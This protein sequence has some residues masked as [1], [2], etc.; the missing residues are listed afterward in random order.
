MILVRL[1]I[2]SWMALLA[3]FHEACPQEPFLPGKPHPEYSNRQLMNSGSD[4][5]K[6]SNLLPFCP[7]P[8][9]QGILPASA[10]FALCQALSIQR[11]MQLGQ[12]G[13]DG[14]VFSASYLFDS[15]KGGKDCDTG[16]SI[17]KAIQ[18]MQENGVCTT[19]AYPNSRYACKPIEEKQAISAGSLHR[20]AGVYRLF[21]A[22]NTSG[23]EKA[24]AVRHC[25]G[26]PDNPRPVVAILNFNLGFHSWSA[27]SGNWRLVPLDTMEKNLLEALVVVGYDDDS[28]CF[29]LMGSFGASWGEGGFAKIGYEDFGAAVKYALVLDSGTFFF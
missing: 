11:T 9:D 6:Q 12:G 8:A 19:D 5:P 22:N 1:W 7:I 24:D 4:I 3:T 28:R 23:Q 21:G 15:L 17:S 20:I 16:I 13:P 14:V 25:L 10:T 18:F 2:L 26:G 27:L 29:T